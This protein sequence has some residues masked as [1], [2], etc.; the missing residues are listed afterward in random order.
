[1]YYKLLG[2]YGI[3]IGL[4][5]ELSLI[6]PAAAFHIAG[7]VFLISICLAPLGFTFITY[8]TKE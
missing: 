8:E 4:I 6:D 5:Y 1:M 2:F 3:I 7:G